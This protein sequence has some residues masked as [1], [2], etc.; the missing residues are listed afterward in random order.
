M[1]KNDTFL[2]NQKLQEAI[3]LIAVFLTII[4]GMLL[5]WNK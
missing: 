4:I 2:A 3:I 5:S 1:K